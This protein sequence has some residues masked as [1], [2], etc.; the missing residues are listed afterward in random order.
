M[1]DD[2][3]FF[4]VVVKPS[5][6]EDRKMST[7][8]KKHRKA[9]SGQQ[10]VEESSHGTN[11]T[12]S[13]T[14]S[15]RTDKS[16]SS[17][18]NNNSHSSGGA[19]AAF[20]EDVEGGENNPIEF[21]L[22]EFGSGLEFGQEF[23]QEFSQGG[24]G[25]GTFAGSSRDTSS[26]R[27]KP[28]S[29]RDLGRRKKTDDTFGGSAEFATDPFNA[30]EEEDIKFADGDES[31]LFPDENPFGN[32]DPFAPKKEP[33]KK[34]SAW[35]KREQWKQNARSNSGPQRGPRGP[36]RTAPRR[37]NST[38][39]GLDLM[40]VVDGEGHSS[41]K[42]ES[43]RRLPREDDR[44]A[45][46]SRTTSG[47]SRLASID[48]GA[49]H[50]RHE[51]EQSMHSSHT[52]SSDPSKPPTRS[53]RGSSLG[54]T[55]SDGSLDPVISNRSLLGQ[56]PPQRGPPQRHKSSAGTSMDPR[57]GASRRLRSRRADGSSSNL[58]G[59]YNDS[60]HPPPPPD[61]DDEDDD[62]VGR[63]PGGSRD[64]KW[65]ND[66]SRNQE[67]IMSMYKDGT[68]R[69]ENGGNLGSSG[70][71][72]VDMESL[73]ISQEIVTPALESKEDKK[74]RSALSKFK[75]HKKK[76]LKSG[77]DEAEKSPIDS[78]NIAGRSR[79][80]LLERIGAVDESSSS[81]RPSSSSHKGGSTYSDRIL[82]NQHS[83]KR[84]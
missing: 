81:D 37:H 12:R 66:R 68:K 50:V 39:C 71:L 58:G 42:P 51:E 47:Q 20:D 63:T 52:E 53:R 5:S 34:M 69:K 21:G 8:L 65:A 19:F 17:S 24:C 16:K 41:R 43:R 14:A 33:P 44:R 76:D 57:T 45:P 60:D 73:N 23:G 75:M 31:A 64:K 46:P 18:K 48:T 4:S 70:D 59:L 49:G 28:Q 84:N 10:C 15:T 40:G 67:M 7:Y 1:N 54:Y 2:D 36:Q 3:P 62:A 9:A 77:D 72:N 80:S 35:E 61:D 32:S 83:R 38:D 78:R 27:R 74:R 79:G 30:F 82:S 55:H 26:G 11:S 22:S 13:T 6:G 25:A 56:R 29:I